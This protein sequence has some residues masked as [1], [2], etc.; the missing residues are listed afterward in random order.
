MIKKGQ[1]YKV[2]HS[3]FNSYN[4][5][6]ENLELEFS[7]VLTLEDECWPDENG[8]YYDFVDVFCN[9]RILTIYTYQLY[10]IDEEI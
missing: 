6:K 3:S 4:L 7:F 5:N 1:I 2:K 8:E 10:K 9:N